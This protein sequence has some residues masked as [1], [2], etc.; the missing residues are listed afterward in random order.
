VAKQDDIGLAFK[1]KNKKKRKEVPL[2]R[3]EP[4][5]P[6]VIVNGENTGKRAV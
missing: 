5:I 3:E 1:K 4:V 2:S 6:Q